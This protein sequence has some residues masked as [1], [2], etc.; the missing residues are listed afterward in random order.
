MPRSFWTHNRIINLVAFAACVL[1]VASGAFTY[2]LIANIL[3]HSSVESALQTLVA[4]IAVIEIVTITIILTVAQV[5]KRLLQ[6]NQSLERRQQAILDALSDCV[7]EID[8]HDRIVSVNPACRQIFANTPETMRG[9]PINR[10]L[11]LT[12]LGAQPTVV[13]AQRTN[14]E[15]FAAEV[16]ASHFTID[17]HGARRH[18]VLSIR[19]VDERVQRQ[20]LNDS[21]LRQFAD[22]VTQVALLRA[23]HA[24]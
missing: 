1:A 17:A 6:R 8:E 20:R 3:N 2:W 12:P 7:I 5:G 11:D 18:T 13:H 16:A 23:G 21:N 22:V 24:T 19:D 10:W 14:G 15:D 9:Q 4:D